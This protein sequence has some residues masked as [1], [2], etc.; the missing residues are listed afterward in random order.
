MPE[1]PIYDS[2]YFDVREWVDQKTWETLG[3][4]AASMIDPRIVAVADQLRIHTDA[5][6]IINNWH[7][8]R[9]GEK[10]FDS[11]G[12]RAVWDKTGGKLSQHRRGAAADLKSRKYTPGQMLQIIK[13]HAGVYQELGLTTVE[14]LQYTPTWLHCDV[15]ILTRR[16]AAIARPFFIVDPV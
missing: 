12:F 10:L 13:D 9:A 15:R 3:P 8:R 14:N 5:P 16:W 1:F 6:I 7:S 4:E 11:S 2:E